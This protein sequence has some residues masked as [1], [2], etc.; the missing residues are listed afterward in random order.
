M[1]GNGFSKGLEIERNLMKET[2]NGVIILLHRPLTPGFPMRIIIKSDTEIIFRGIM[3]AI[4]EEEFVG[5][6]TELI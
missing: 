4:S 6:P 1:F 5:I 2:V 3:K